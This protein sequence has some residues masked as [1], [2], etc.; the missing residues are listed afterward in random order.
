[1]KKWHKW[2]CHAD[3]SVFISAD[4]LRESDRLCGVVPICE[5]GLFRYEKSAA[6]G[7]AARKIGVF[8]YRNRL[9]VQM[10]KRKPALPLTRRAGFCYNRP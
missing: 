10:G 4:S 8:R 1:M 2:L 9:G 6:N 5:S 3:S 7:L